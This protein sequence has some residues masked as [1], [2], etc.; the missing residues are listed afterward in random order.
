M[1]GMHGCGSSTPKF[2]A[3][4]AATAGFAI[5]LHIPKLLIFTWGAMSESTQIG[6]P[7]AITFRFEVPLSTDG[8]VPHVHIHNPVDTATGAITFSFA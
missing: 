6:L 5:E 4:A 8:V 2:F 7:S 1:D 3:V